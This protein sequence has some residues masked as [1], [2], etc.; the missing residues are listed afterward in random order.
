MTGTPLQNNL[1][2][3][4]SLLGFILPSVFQEHK[5]DLESIFNAK[6]KTMDESH[7]A[8]LSVQRI[9]RAR[10]MM[11][12]FILR[13]K[14]YQVLKHL[15][16][17]TRRVEYCELT[18]SQR[19]IYEAEQKRVREVLEA[20]E[21]G[22]KPNSKETTNCMMNLRKASIHPLLFRRIYDDKTL[23]KM[24]KQA[25]K[26]EDYQASD[27][28]LVYEDMTVMTDSE[29]N[30]LCADHPDY[31]G[32]FVLDE[33]RCM[34]SGKVLRLCQL[35]TDFKANGD[36][37]LIF[38]QFTMVMN[39]LELVMESLRMKF[40]RLDGS[41]DIN[42]RQTMIDEFY[43]DT[44]VTVFM[45][46]T[47]AG[48]AGINLACAN[49]VIIFDSSFN[50]QDDIQAENRAH[51][52]GQTRDVEVIRLVTKGTIEEHI[53]RLGETKLLLDDKVAGAGEAEDDAKKVEKAG[54]KKVQEML[55]MEIKG[56]E[57]G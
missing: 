35:L 24:A 43:E 34:D 11:A 13:R 29:L 53:Y 5:E 38:S 52:V 56:E 23:S 51:R 15:P 42:D 40:F 41:T 12:P 2:E 46:S 31:L 54:E 45:L 6:A 21:A 25:V 36:R 8:L 27:V 14:K 33:D 48:G 47:K 20:R 7:S 10:S 44:N 57:A 19:A 3:L 50:P 1:E 55:L 39:I 18:A 28:D 26:E 9:A 30:K 37:V 49:K 16:T 22:A 17:K 32:K 4:A